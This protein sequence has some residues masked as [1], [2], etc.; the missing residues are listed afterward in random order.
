MCITM[1]RVWTIRVEEVLDKLVE[2]NVQNL[3]YSS[4]AELVREAVRVFI[5]ERNI[6]R[7]GLNTL[8]RERSDNSDLTPEQALKRLRSITTDSEKIKSITDE[9]RSILENLLFNLTGGNDK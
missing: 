3:G 7:L 4:K 2:D 1:S 9:E 5:L 8:D 6:G